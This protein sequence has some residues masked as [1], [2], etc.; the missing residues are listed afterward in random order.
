MQWLYK[1]ERKFGRYSIPNL[2]IYITLTMAAVFVMN[3]V[4]LNFSS[5]LA[6]D[7]NLVLRGQIWRLITFVVVP[8]SGNVLMVL[9]SLYFY[10]FIG[11]SLE[12]AWGDFKFDVYYL[13][14]IFGAILAAFITGYG[15]NTYLNLSLFL[16]FAQLFPEE[17]VLL[18]YLIPVKV[19]WLA[20]LDWALFAVSFIFG[21]WPTRL[22]I[23]MSIVNFIIFFGPGFFKRIKQNRNY[24]ET[25]K[26]WQQEMRQNKNNY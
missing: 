18:F 4:G 7:R 20:W 2:M 22:A 6:L 24:S 5:Y 3:A 19:K 14:G 23:V 17:R 21:N 25:R 10:Y 11:S 15:T 26:N 16:A 13:F 12:N 1:L 9:I 8:P